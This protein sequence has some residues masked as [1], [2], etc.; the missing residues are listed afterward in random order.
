MTNPIDPDEW[1]RPNDDK[2]YSRLRVVVQA[3]QEGTTDSLMAVELDEVTH[4]IERRAYLNGRTR[5]PRPWS[6]S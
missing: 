3:I 2:L 4:A 6:L 5:Q 1:R